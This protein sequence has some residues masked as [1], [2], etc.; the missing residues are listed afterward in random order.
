MYKHCTTNNTENRDVS[1][2]LAV[3]FRSSSP[4]QG[5]DL[6][7]LSLL[8]LLANPHKLSG[9][10]CSCIEYARNCWP[11]FFFYI[12][13]AYFVL[14]FVHTCL[15]YSHRLSFKLEF[16]IKNESHSNTSNDIV[17]VVVSSSHLFFSSMEFSSV[18]SVRFIW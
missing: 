8:E 2:F 7:C 3:L 18:V 17:R 16:F 9:A 6:N 15:P 4:F 13:L 14:V 1:I 5:Y 10:V 12:S 11:K